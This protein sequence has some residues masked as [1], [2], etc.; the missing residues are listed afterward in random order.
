MYVL[1]LCS[2]NGGPAHHKYPLQTFPSEQKTYM[3]VYIY[4]NI[5]TYI[6]TY[7]YMYM[8]ICLVIDFLPG[9]IFPLLYKTLRDLR[10][11]FPTVMR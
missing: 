10:E 4:L 3:Y 11:M 6:Y 2:E 7:M 5:Y 1:T 8:Q 9:A